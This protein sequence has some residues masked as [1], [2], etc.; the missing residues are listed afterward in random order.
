[1]WG[2]AVSL[3]SGDG[4]G[5]VRD[6]VRL[7]WPAAV[8]V[9]QASARR[10]LDTAQV[11]EAPGR[12]RPLRSSDGRSIWAILPGPTPV[13][14][15]HVGVG[16]I[17]SMAIMT[18]TAAAGPVVEPARAEP[19]RRPGHRV[20]TS[21]GLSQSQ[22]RPRKRPSCN[23]GGGRHG[24]RGGN[25]CRRAV[26]PDRPVNGRT[27]RKRC[28]RYVKNLVTVVA[29]GFLRR[30]RRGVIRPFRLELGRSVVSARP[31]PES[32]A[33]EHKRLVRAGGATAG[34]PEPDGES[35]KRTAQ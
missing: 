31:V 16:L 18:G 20:A 8:I 17:P 30:P 14:I 24:R 11:G 21:H 19:P 3:L 2:S 12:R 7:G 25:R 35:R 34:C 10:Q 26:G 9:S 6:L 32:T 28:D 27:H 4:V 22:G 13:T 5:G 23:A 33:P 1:M 29:A 15:R